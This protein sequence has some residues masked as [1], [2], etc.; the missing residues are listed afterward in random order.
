MASWK[1]SLKVIG[2][3]A[4][5]IAAAVGGPLAGSAVS[6]IESAIGL[7][8]S[9]DLPARQD[10]VA[11]AMTIATPETLL[12]LKQADLAFQAKMAEL[13]FGDV[14][15]LTKLA[16]DDRDSARKREIAVKDKTPTILAFLVTLGF[17]GIL[18]SLRV[19]TIPPDARDILSQM[20][21]A[22][23]LGFGGVLGYYFGSSSGQARSTELLSQAPS[24]NS[25][26]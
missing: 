2:G 8:A 10:A 13:G 5:M 16:A 26:K 20:T 7:K 14:E 18:V 25:S 19:G 21:G 6:S 24:I 9:G 12:A 4:P 1:D 3:I 11:A 17:F 22:L 15:T 23:Q